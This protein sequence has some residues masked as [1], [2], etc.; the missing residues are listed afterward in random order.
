[1]A[2]AQCLRLAHSPVLVDALTSIHPPVYLQGYVKKS[3]FSADAPVSRS[4]VLRESPF[5][6][7]DNNRVSNGIVNSS[8]RF[9]SETRR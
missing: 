1:M 8:A 2:L 4:Q 6:N 5:S 9:Y 3:A 7:P